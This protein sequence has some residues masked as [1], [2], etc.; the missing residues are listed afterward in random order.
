MQARC[1]DETGKDF[2]DIRKVKYHNIRLPDKEEII[3][4]Y[5]KEAVVLE[6]DVNGKI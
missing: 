6:I 2:T 5:V 1:L 4:E 3:R